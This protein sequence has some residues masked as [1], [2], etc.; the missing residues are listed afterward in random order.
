MV[1]LLNSKKLSQTSI[2]KPPGWPAVFGRSGR[3]FQVRSE[4]STAGALENQK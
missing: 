3:F 4:L 2:K 1:V